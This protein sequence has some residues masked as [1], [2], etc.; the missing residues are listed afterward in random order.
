M[1]IYIYIYW[2]IEK[3]DFLLHNNDNLVLKNK[4]LTHCLWRNSGLF[5]QR[6]YGHFKKILKQDYHCYAKE[7]YM[8]ILA[9]I[10]QILV[11][12]CLVAGWIWQ[13]VSSMHTG[14]ND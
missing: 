10:V 13:K 8:Y 6:Q 1:S 9:E 5:G 12:N 3:R 2:V 14:A 4:K 11:L 7:I